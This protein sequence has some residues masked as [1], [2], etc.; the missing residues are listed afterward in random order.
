M[1]KALLLVAAVVAVLDWSLFVL[2]HTGACPTS[3]SAGQ[4]RWILGILVAC[5]LVAGLTGAER[6]TWKIGL[7]LAAVAVA[8]AWSAELLA[9]TRYL[10]PLPWSADAPGIVLLLVAAMGGGL[11]SGWQWWTILVLP[12]A[13]IGFFH[14]SESLWD[15][16]VECFP[17]NT[18]VVRGLIFL[19]V[20][21]LVGAAVARRAPRPA[22]VAGVALLVVPLIG[23]GWAAYR[24]WRPIDV[25]PKQ[26]PAIAEID[27]RLTLHVGGIPTRL[28]PQE[29][30]AGGHRRQPRARGEADPYGHVLHPLHGFDP[31]CEISDPGLGAIWVQGDP[32]ERIERE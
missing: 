31:G 15:P 27:G 11:L 18:A 6:L 22:G 8:G 12:A 26:P 24:H 2:V 21:V 14:L 20:A 29:E 13:S 17:Q 4:E 30:R 32:I 25:R 9:R 10:E 5:A 19:P 7:A 3:F 23:L 1:R 28:G 16:G